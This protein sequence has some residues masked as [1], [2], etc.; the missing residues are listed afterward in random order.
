MA[1]RVHTEIPDKFGGAINAAALATYVRRVASLMEE[2]KGLGKDIAEVCAEADAAGLASKREIRRL[3][4]ESLM[5]P[6]VLQAQLSRLDDLRAALGTFA[7]T[8]LGAAAVEREAAPPHANGHDVASAPQ[9]KMAKPKKKFA[10]QPVTAPRRRGRPSKT[11]PSVDE[12]LA[13]SR[14]HLGGNGDDLPPAA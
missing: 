9:A 12:A 5:E 14:Q 11:T 1:Q 7:A 2:Q 6:D 13:L 10:E 3:A 8:P 4:R